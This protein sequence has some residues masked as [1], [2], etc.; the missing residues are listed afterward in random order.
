V[1]DRSTA[2]ELDQLAARVATIRPMSNSNPHAFYEERSEVASKI[3]GLAAKL[4]NPQAAVVEAEPSAP[5]GRQ[6][7]SRSVRH[8]TGRTVLVLNRRAASEHP[9]Y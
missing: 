6:T 7:V 9:F 4:R 5:V 2:D 8:V 1:I 3:R